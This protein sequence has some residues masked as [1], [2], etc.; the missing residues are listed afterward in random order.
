M[1]PSSPELTH[2]FMFFVSSSDWRPSV[3]LAYCLSTGEFSQFSPQDISWD[4]VFPQ[5]PI[6]PDSTPSVSIANLVE[7]RLA[8]CFLDLQHFTAVVNAATPAHPVPST[9]FQ[10]IVS[11]I[12]YRL[13]ALQETLADFLPECL[14]LGMLAFLTTTFQMPGNVVRYPYL[15]RRFRDCYR[16]VEKTPDLADVVRWLLVVGAISVCGPDEEWLRAAWAVDVAEE[17]EQSWDRTRERLRDVMWIDGLHDEPGR[18][19][20]EALSSSNPS[21]SITELPTRQSP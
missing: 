8:Q 19:A 15:A 14:R 18:A 4:P 11:S 10:G 3:D 20:F 7:P 21:T 1:S 2:I 9:V 13:I 6:S 17:E 5:S 16:A 12:Q